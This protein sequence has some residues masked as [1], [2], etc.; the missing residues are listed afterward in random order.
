MFCLHFLMYIE[1]ANT[2]WTFTIYICKCKKKWTLQL[3][4]HIS[5]LHS[6]GTLSLYIFYVDYYCS[7]PFHMYIQCDSEFVLQISNSKLRM[8]NLK[9]E[10]KSHNLNSNNVHRKCTKKMYMQNVSKKC[11]Y[12]I[13]L[14]I[15][16]YICICKL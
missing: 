4:V 5:Y 10:V 6:A 9:F 7:R 11:K 16:L 14:S 1:N 2:T 12:I 13:L 8:Y 3:H 15:F